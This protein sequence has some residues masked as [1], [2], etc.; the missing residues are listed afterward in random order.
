MKAARLKEQIENGEYRVDPAAVAEAI[1]RRI[2]GVEAV[3]DHGL[4]AALGREAQRPGANPAQNECSYPASSESA[5][6]KTTPGG[7]SATAPIHVTFRGAPGG[8]AFSNIA[9]VR[10][11][12]QTQSS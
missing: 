6:R 3:R 8:R 10:A 2:G 4:G 7:P 9:A 1:L 5:S 11:G 12:M